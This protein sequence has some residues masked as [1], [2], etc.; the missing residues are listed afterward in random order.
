VEEQSPLS[1]VLSGSVMRRRVGTVLHA[2]LERI[3]PSGVLGKAEQYRATVKMLVRASGMAPSDCDAAVVQVMR[4]LETAL[5]SPNGRWVLAAH[6]DAQTELAV[7]IADD[8]TVRNVRPDRIFAAGAEPLSTG[9][10]HIWIVDYKTAEHGEAGGE[11]FYAK[12]R[13]I[14]APIV[15]RYA[16]AY[17]ALTNDTRPVC[18]AL[19]FPAAD[20]L[21]LL[22]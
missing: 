9:D 13:E 19:Y 4:Q 7:S 21:E 18:C 10:S 12:Q 15:A 16:E 6:P 5:N 22:S 20:R 11:E 1:R 14:Y 2:M 17:R 8:G 3:A